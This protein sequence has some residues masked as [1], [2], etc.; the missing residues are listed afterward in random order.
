[1]AKILMV[2][3][4]A[5]SL[6]L[7]DGTS[8]PTGYWAEEVVRSHQVL[9]EAGIAVDI[10]TP[11][12]RPAVPDQGSLAADAPETAGFRQYLD[13]IKDQLD[14]PKDLAKV[15]GADYDGV[16]LP[17]GHAPM[18]DLTDNRDL[19]RILTRALRKDQV[20]ASLCHGAAGLLSADDTTGF[21]F[22]GL[23]ITAFTDEEENQGGLGDRSPWFLATRLAERGAV[24]ETGPAWSDT[25]VVQGKLITGQNPQSSVS[26]ARAVVEALKD[27][28]NGTALDLHGAAH[29]QR[30]RETGGADGH[31]WRYGTQIL[32]LDSIGNKSG[33]Q[34]THALIYRPWNGAYLV[35]ASAGGTDA[36]P[37][38]SLNLQARPDTR[39][40][41]R[42]Q[43]IPVR[44]RVATAAE[45]PA[46][47]A[48][49]VDAWPDYD[50]YQERTDREI[51][52]VVL[53][54]TGEPRPA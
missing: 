22:A 13:G 47:W 14:R 6:T 44:A 31:D 19:G 28:P 53:E 3:S 39:I 37:A 12:G 41:V 27:I 45:K 26:T 29:I 34:R 32:L 35:V 18:T 2:L 43:I 10:V 24:L 7:A 5:D 38:W 30:Y 50:N 42:D 8:H 36:P 51:P 11:G 54:P 25:V 15:S 9:T 52:I 1:M 48:E 40:Q 17:G 23:R 21:P 4:S 16:Y 33:Q 46:M 20:V 49:M